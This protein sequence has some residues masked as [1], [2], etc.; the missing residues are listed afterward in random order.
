MIE[1]QPFKSTL[2]KRLEKVAFFLNRLSGGRL[3]PNHLTITGLIL[4]IP[5]AT[6][7]ADGLLIAGALVLLFACL[8]D[9]FDGA[10]ARH[11]KTTSD[12]GG[13]LDASSDRLG[14]IIIFMGLVAYLHQADAS[15]SIM[16]L[17][18]GVLGCSILISY[19]KAKGE[20]L[21]ANRSP[22][23][24]K[25]LNQRFSGGLLNYEQ[26]VILIALTILS[27]QWFIGFWLLLLSSLI[28]VAAR[29]YKIYK[30]LSNK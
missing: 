13:W 1:Y 17:A 10:L 16:V 3:K 19:V 18:I 28:T 21:L 23:P 29:S 2:K 26:R 5:A 27:Q 12:F 30:T 4:H 14:E 11:Q 6:L 9:A 22:K 7:I 20:A 15:Q 8:L 24:L 25:D